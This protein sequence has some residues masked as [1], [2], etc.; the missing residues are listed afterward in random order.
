MKNLSWKEQG[1]VR[2][3]DDYYPTPPNATYALLAHL[4]IPK[5]I[6]LWESFCGHGAISK[7]LE[8]VHSNVYSTELYPDR[9]GIGGVDFFHAED[10]IPKKPFWIVTNPPYKYAAESVRKAFEYGA[11]RIIMLLRFP[12][13]A[14]AKSREDILENGH[15]MRVLLIKERVPFVPYGW[16]GTSSSPTYESAWFIWDRNYKATYPSEIVVRRISLRQGE[17]YAHIHNLPL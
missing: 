7:I 5:N 17:D 12:F 2:R 1:Y 4:S 16:E 11:E 13:L 10:Y 14:S 6:I 3:E 8:K 15:L 9:Y